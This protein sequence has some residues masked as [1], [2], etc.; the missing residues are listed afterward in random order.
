MESQNRQARHNRNNS[1]AVTS[2]PCSILAPFEQQEQHLSGKLLWHD[3]ENSLTSSKPSSLYTI[4]KPICT[5]TCAEQFGVEEKLHYFSNSSKY[6][7]IGII[8]DRDGERIVPCNCR[9]LAKISQ[10]SSIGVYMSRGGEQCS[11]LRTTTGGELE[12]QK[13]S[14]ILGFIFTCCWRI[15]RKGVL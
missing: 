11:Q 6:S 15:R 13:H 1:G 14:W 10:F 12:N 3:L 9:D 4:S 2:I 5:G 8:P 7:K